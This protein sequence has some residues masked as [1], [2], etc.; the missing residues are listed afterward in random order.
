MRSECEELK[1]QLS[2]NEK[3]VEVHEAKVEKLSE[4]QE[5]WKKQQEQEQV[6]LKEIMDK[7]FQQ[8]EE[9][10]TKTVL[11]VIK[12]KPNVVRDSVEKKKCVVVFGLKE[13]VLPVRHIREKQER[14]TVEKV[15]ETVCEDQ[16]GG[17]KL[18]EE[19]EEIFRLGKYEEN[20]HRPLKIRMRSQV[21]AE[22]LIAKSWKLASKEDYRRVWIRRDLNE[23]ER[24]KVNELWNEAK[25]KNMNRTET[26]KKSFYWRVKDMRLRKWYVTSNT[27]E[28][29]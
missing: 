27:D 11:K 13:E 3:K 29:N 2:S 18:S 6:S 8:R 22:E 5:V 12:E 20:K 23:D 4:K 26:E 15:V 14:K 10:V 28:G 19:I 24:V 1:K 16:D 7:Q 17:N 9:V 21:A 25:E